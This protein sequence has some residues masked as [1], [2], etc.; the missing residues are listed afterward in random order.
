MGKLGTFYNIALFCGL[1]MRLA[2]VT[3]RKETAH[4]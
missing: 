3:V 1:Y 2:E 4:D